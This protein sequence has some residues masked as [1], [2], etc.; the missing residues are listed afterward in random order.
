MEYSIIVFIFQN[1][2][3]VYMH[4]LFIL[5]IFIIIYHAFPQNIPLEG[6]DKAF[7]VSSFS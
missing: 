3:G 4:S 7:C 2:F 1:I 5:R 6:T